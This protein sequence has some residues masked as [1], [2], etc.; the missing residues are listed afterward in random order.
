MN[1]VVV[2]FRVTGRMM[3]EVTMIYPHKAASVETAVANANKSLCGVESL[4]TQERIQ[5]HKT[6]ES[7]THF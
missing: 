5:N 3:E 7:I 4:D 2:Y 6:T 1:T